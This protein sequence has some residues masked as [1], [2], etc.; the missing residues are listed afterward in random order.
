M[1]FTLVDLHTTG[2][3]TVGA[4]AFGLL[5]S[6]HFA[7]P[8]RLNHATESLTNFVGGY[9]DLVVVRRHRSLLE[10]LYLAS[11]IRSLFENFGKIFFQFHLFRVN[12]ILLKF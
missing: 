5:L 1:N 7:G 12:A 9:F 10:S 11:Y 4:L 2:S 8:A 6:S 3:P